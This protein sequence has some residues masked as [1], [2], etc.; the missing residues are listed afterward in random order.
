MGLH[1]S[2]RYFNLTPKASSRP[3]SAFNFGA[4]VQHEPVSHSGIVGVPLNDVTVKLIPDD[5]TRCEVRVKGPNIMAGYFEDPEKTAECFDEEGYFITG[6]AMRFVD[7][8]DPNKGLRF[9]GR[10]SEDFKLLTGTWVRA[11][12]L[13][14]E[15]LACLAPLAADVVITGHDRGEIGVLVFPNMEAL[16]SAGHAVRDADGALSGDSLALPRL[17]RS[18]SREIAP[19]SRWPRVAGASRIER[20]LES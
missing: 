3:H 8:E 6:D 14:L 16:D 5:E 12:G 15:L 11:A 7:A 2:D 19:N 4:L 17:D 10:I 13:R 20:D 1:L 18:S 9:D